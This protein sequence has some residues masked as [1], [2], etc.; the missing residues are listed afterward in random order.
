MVTFLAVLLM[1]STFCTILG[2]LESVIIS[3]NKCITTKPLQQGYLYHKL[4]KTFSK[5]YRRHYE[6]ISKFNVGLNALLRESLSEPE[7]YGD[8][9][10]KFKKL[11][12]RND[13]SFQF[14]KI[15]M[16]YRRI[17]YNLNVMRQSACLVFNPI[18][19]DNCNAFFNSGVRLCD[20]P[21]IK[22][23]I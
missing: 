3:R 19:V 14:R 17:G 10:Y 15:I 7:V 23:F 12:E 20:G 1:A 8:L 4:R 11:I 9:V 16:R 2:L 5:F 22:L 18:M 6:L 13:F 21:D